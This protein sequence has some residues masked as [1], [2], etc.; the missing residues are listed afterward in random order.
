MYK[1]IMGVTWILAKMQLLV[2]PS[3]K[4]SIFGTGN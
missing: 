4:N 2:M 1:Y 3:S